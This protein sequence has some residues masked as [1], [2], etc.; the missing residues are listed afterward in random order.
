MP[1][2]HS[3]SISG[4]HMQEAGADTILELGF[5][6]ANGLEYIRTGVQEAGLLVD[7]FAPRLSFFWG[8]GMNFYMEVAK[9]RAARRLWAHLVQERFKP[10]NPRSLQLRAHCQTSGWSLTER[11]P[12]N[13][14]IRT[15]IEAMAAVFGGCQSLHTNSLDEA[16]A[17]P[18]DFSARIARNTQL[19]LQEESGIPRVVDPWGGSYFME[20]LTEQVYEGA[21]RL[22]EEVEE[23]GGMARAVTTGM[24]KLRI[25]EAA[26]RRQARID[27]GQEVIVGVNKYRLNGQEVEGSKDEKIQVLAVDNKAVLLAQKKRLQRLGETRDQSRVETCLKA[28]TDEAAVE[29]KK[30]RKNLLELAVEAALVRCTVGEISDALEK[31][32][33]RHQPSSTVVTGAYAQSYVPNDGDPSAEAEIRQTIEKAQAFE[34]LHGR[35]PRI[36]VAKLGQ[37]G[38]DRGAKVIASSLADLGFDVDIGPL[39]QTP[40]EVCQQAIDSD[41]HIIGISTLAAGHRTLVPELIQLL[42]EQGADNIKVICGGVIPEQDYPTLYKKGVAA[43]FGPSTRIPEAAREII[44][45]VDDQQSRSQSRSR[46][47]S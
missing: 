43:I 7:D 45:L 8:I 46:S 4:Y 26:T 44:K 25:E 47:K 28:L 24:P 10:Q 41:V 36:L 12:H 11:Q 5:T 33:G 35:R 42:Q 31:V 22:V 3:I 30:K 38:H 18:T 19:V 15:T 16:V 29:D 14:I 40:A 9:M 34:E 1:K 37:D 20:Q 21:R 2:F 6:L 32:W 23:M 13:N 17:L 27:S 39:F